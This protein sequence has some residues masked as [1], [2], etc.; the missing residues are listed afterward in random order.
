MT[1][2]AAPAL[3]YLAL[4]VAVGDALARPILRPATGLHRLAAAFLVGLLVSSWVTY[5]LASVLAGGLEQ[6]LGPADII[7]LIAAAVA[8]G[9]RFLLAWRRR[10]GA[11][12]HGAASGTVADHQAFDAARESR[13]DWAVIAALGVLTAWMFLRTLGYDAASATLWM[14]RHEWGDIGPTMGIAQSFALGH[15][16][17]TQYPL[18]AGP[19]I[20]YH[21][22]YYLQAGNLTFLGLDPAAAN[23]VL[24]IPS[25]VAVVALV[26]TLARRLFRS[27]TAARLAAVLFFAHGSLAL[28]P[29]LATVPDPASALSGILGLEHYLVSGLPFRGE[30]WATWSL[31]VFLNQRHLASAIGLLL[32]ALLFVLD[33]LPESGREPAGTTAGA[34]LPPAPAPARSSFAARLRGGLM[35]PGLPAWIAVGAGLGLLP[36]WNGVIFVAAA[37]IFAALF[38]VLPTRAQ[39]AALGMTACAVALPQLL[40]LREG[41]A[42]DAAFPTLRLGYTVDPLTP[43]NLVSFVVVDFGPKL[44]LAVVGLAAATGRARRVFVALAVLAV[45]AFSVRLSV[46]IVANHKLLNTWLV[47]ADAFAA[48]GLVTLWRAG[49][50]RRT[51]SGGK[52]RGRHWLGLGAGL[53]GRV[54][55]VALAGIILVG[56]LIDLAPI[57]N[58][59]RVAYRLDGEA[60]YDWVRTTT[61]P[62]D[63]FLT[64]LYVVDPIVLAGRRLY[65]GWP[66]YAWSAGYDTY[67]RQAQY[68]AM[69]QATD[70]ATLLTL[71]HANG[72]AYV[73][74]DDT[75]RKG[76]DMVRRPNEALYQATL[77]VA[78]T[79]TENRHAHL[80]IYRVP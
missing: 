27:A 31:N 24:A 44:L 59:G 17:P 70:A 36:L 60:L 26:L 47:L 9:A 48:W 49:R 76:T 4:M 61:N 43:A 15:N 66:I 55:A 14:G 25:V 75:L 65:Y 46:D 79:D 51:P 16:F 34:A 40:F 2:A 18:F 32:L 35:D 80:V 45:L 1:A 6:P 20:R 50:G 42:P 29:Y 62:D 56:G 33:R 77:P 73:A 11:A 38:L 72:I 23:N 5:A 64:D 21:F 71:L 3:L 54:G 19:P 78:F 8:L 37:A 7:V 39:M 12:N 53:V 22:L 57:K 63:V 52:G 30:D 28:L 74:W 69:L 10:A 68:I 58:D 13:G 67:P 41:G